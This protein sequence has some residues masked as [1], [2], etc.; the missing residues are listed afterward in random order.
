MTLSHRARM[1]IV[2]SAV[3]ML[4]LGTATTQA[5]PPGAGASPYQITGIQP[6]QTADAF[7]LTIRGDR[8]PTYTMYELYN[9]L[10][11]VID[12]ADATFTNSLA[13][14]MKVAQGPVAEVKGS[15][16]DNQKPSVTRIEIL[17]SE[18]RGYA[19]ERAGNDIVVKF[20][21]EMRAADTAAGNK[22]PQATAIK[23][24]TVENEAG[25]T[26]V[27][28]HADGPIQRFTKARLKK[29]ADRPD[30][31]YIDIAGV[32]MAKSVPSV[33][34]VGT[35]LNRIRTAARE[36]GVRIVF[37]SGLDA[38]FNYDITPQTDGLKIAIKDATADGKESSDDTT[39][40][41]AAEPATEAKG[42]A[43][44]KAPTVPARVAAAQDQFG[45]T[46]Y[47]KQRITV[48]FFKIDLHN[49]FRL[50]GEISGRNI[51]VDESV[52]GSLTLA[53][54]DVPWDFVLDIILN[55]KDLQKVER[56]NTIVISPKSKGFVWPEQMT[57][58]L[59]IRSD[60]TVA[61]QESL[62]I[63]QRIETPKGVIE[64]KKL[65]H[66]GHT[67]Y[68][69]G[70]FA[71]ALSLYEE[72][73]TKWPENS[74]LAKRV[75]ALC[76]VQLG[77]NAKAV[78]YAKAALKNDPK[79]YDAAL[80]AAIGL[81]NMKKDA[82]AKEYFDLAV[83]GPRPSSEALTSYA[84]FC[85]QNEN[86]VTTLLLLAKH[87]NLYGDT[88]DTM[89]ARARIYDKQGDTAKAVKEYRALLLSGYELAPDLERYIK[90]RL[91]VVPQ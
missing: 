76:L 5:S 22:S 29:G 16:V 28:L 84:A 44:T 71:G 1:L 52:S 41:P 46:G 65:I 33:I 9:P 38:L 31:L 88:L 14:P 70:D 69:A 66:E 56:F 25:Q 67:K 85:E 10:R 23:T 61:P 55:L 64:A 17:L 86:F 12:I 2:L 47:N 53:L 13:L 72:A 89:L 15:L 59:T 7:L 32:S 68:Q 82:A 4:L 57:D 34:K 43:P 87:T 48:D 19:V 30:R 91:A 26:N 24:I 35:A 21:S 90:G 36:K 20:S 45:L 50:L 73:F 78:H 27:Y 8:A 58:K 11:I 40:A 83:S 6:E 62:S 75:A 18:D 63:K 77:Q 49:V 51:V 37:D 60:G 79:D 81:A 54:N 74:Q 3:A 39:T 80:Q 42:S